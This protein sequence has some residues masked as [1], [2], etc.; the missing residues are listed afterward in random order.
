MTFGLSCYA[1]QA[2]TVQLPA[3]G[4]TACYDTNGISVSCK[5]TGQ[6]GAVKAG[7]AWPK[8]RF[9]NNNNGMVIDK[10]TGLIWLQNASCLGQKKWGDAVAVANR[11][12]PSSAPASCGLKDGSR[13]GQWR[14]PNINELESLIDLSN[15]SG[16]AL[17]AG[18]SFTTVQARRYWSSSVRTTDRPGGAPWFVSMY[19]GFIGPYQPGLSYYVWPVRGGINHN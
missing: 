16:I 12:A 15:D 5:G 2:E 6:D 11:L 13:D 9:I 8:P 7:V 3:S 18:H 10:L 17:P 1:I 4:Q 14:L 19:D